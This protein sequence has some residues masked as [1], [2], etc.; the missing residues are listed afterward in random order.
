M[1]VLCGDN[2]ICVLEGSLP[3]VLGIKENNIQLFD[4][5]VIIMSHEEAI[6]KIA[7]LKIFKLF[8][9]LTQ[10]SIKREK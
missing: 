8:H 9:L 7:I 4:Y 3:N 1:S 5:C 2:D 10:K 6:W